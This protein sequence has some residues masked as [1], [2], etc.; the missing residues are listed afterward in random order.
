MMNILFSRVTLIA[1]GASLLISCGGGSSS[2]GVATAPQQGTLNLAPQNFNVELGNS[3][4]VP[5]QLVGSQGVVNQFVS[6]SVSD[7]AVAQVSPAHCVVSSGVD[8]GCMVTVTG[9]KQGPASLTASSQGYGDYSTSVTVITGTGVGTISVTQKTGTTYFTGSPSTNWSVTVNFQPTNNYVVPA[10]NPIYVLFKDPSGFIQAGIK[11]GVPPILQCGLTTNAPTC[12]VSGTW[13][14]SSIPASSKYASGLPATIGITGS[15]QTTGQAFA[16]FN[17]I[18]VPFTPTNIQTPGT[19]S[20]TT[21]NA[22][23]QIYSGMKAPLFVQLN[24]STLNNGN[25]N[26]TLSIPTASQSLVAFYDFTPGNNSPTGLVKSFTKTCNIN[27]DNS[28]IGSP[29]NNGCGFGLVARR[30]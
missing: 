13:N 1:L 23:N 2:G 24:N 30:S 21:Q 28:G 6:F 26:V 18:P 20:V 12:T 9:L 17:P 22:S 25:Y 11:G 14:P 8:A 3:V 4:V 29:G 15:W 10:G 19:L 16:K 5:F 7:P 27:F